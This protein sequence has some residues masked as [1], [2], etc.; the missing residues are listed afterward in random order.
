MKLYYYIYNLD[1]R[2]TRIRIFTKIDT[3]FYM[4]LA[5]LGHIGFLTI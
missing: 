1:V 3:N 2:Y 5:L 4:L